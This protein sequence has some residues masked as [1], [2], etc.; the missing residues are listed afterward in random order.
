MN[1]HS[2]SIRVGPLAVTPNHLAIT[3]GVDVNG[4]WIEPVPKLVTGDLKIWAH[5]S[6]V[7]SI[8]IPGYWIH[9]TGS[10]IPVAAS[11]MPGEKVVY[12]LHG[13]AYSR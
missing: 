13:G 7:S 2:E 5:V 8:R 12:A 9:K 11:P 3:P 6:S 4:V 1:F 10:T